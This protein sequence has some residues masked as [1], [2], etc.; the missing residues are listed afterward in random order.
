MPCGC[1]AT[2]S[3]CSVSRMM[4]CVLGG[5]RSL[6]SSGLRGAPA[7]GSRTRPLAQS[8]S[9]GNFVFLWFSAS[10]FS[11]LLHL[12]HLTL[13]GCVHPLSPTQES[14]AEAWR[15]SAP[16]SCWWEPGL[17]SL[18]LLPISLRVS[19]TLQSPVLRAGWATLSSRS[20]GYHLYQG[21]RHLRP[22]LPMG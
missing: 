8:P 7:H 15:G 19:V 2:S 11:L 9:L 3:P 5:G 17:G 16:G 22:L 1:T 6:G 13:Q 12:G 10:A 14:L 4:R 20:G 18:T 21:P